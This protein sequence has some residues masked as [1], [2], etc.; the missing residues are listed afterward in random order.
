IGISG[1]H[2]RPC[3]RLIVEAAHDGWLHDLKIRGNI[4]IAGRIEGRMANLQD[5]LPSRLAFNARYFRQNWV[6][7]LFKGLRDQ[8]G[9]DYP[10]WMPRTE[11]NH[12]PPPTLRD[13]QW[14]QIAQQV[15]DVLEI[16]VETYPLSRVGAD[17]RP[18]LIVELDRT[19]NA[20]ME[21]RI[22]R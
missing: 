6:T 11:S 18:V 13:R 5:F 10:G 17:A 7:H 9:A 21:R 4:E 12:A 15:K 3:H 2:V 19:A 16:V 20:R 22:F 1:R 8:C 14:K